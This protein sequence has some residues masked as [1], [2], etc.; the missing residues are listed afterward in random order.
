MDAAEK[1]IDPYGLCEQLD[2][3]LSGRGR[4]LF[5]EGLSLERRYLTDPL[6]KVDPGI[7]QRA[8]FVMLSSLF[9]TGSAERGGTVKITVSGHD[10]ETAVVALSYEL[11]SN[12][13]AAVDLL[14]RCGGTISFSGRTENSSTI[15][16]TVPTCG[17]E[18]PDVEENEPDLS[19]DY[20]RLPGLSALRVLIADDEAPIRDL[21]GTIV[22]DAGISAIDFARNG[23]EACVKA[24][25]RHYDLI[26]MDITMPVMSGREAFNHIMSARPD[27]RIVLI[28]GFYNEDFSPETADS[29]GSFGY[30]KKPFNISQIRSMLEKALDR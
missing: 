25:E 15:R 21:L 2:I 6:V 4:S 20:L 16:F 5:P 18:A 3:F 27:A 11:T 26:F 13:E 14:S 9:T 30:I 12:A 17:L 29:H 8:L 23:E 22:S 7:L 1:K 10:H 24:L 28:T 19:I